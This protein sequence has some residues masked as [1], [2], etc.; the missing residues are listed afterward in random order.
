MPGRPHRGDRAA[1]LAERSTAYRARRCQGY[2]RSCAD[3]GH[4]PVLGPCW[5][6][7]RSGG[8]NC[9]SS[10]ANSPTAGSARCPCECR[11]QQCRAE[12]A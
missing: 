5:M 8:T 11:R 3:E 4:R 6:G 9:S 10:L 2:W 12:A 1:T 7:F